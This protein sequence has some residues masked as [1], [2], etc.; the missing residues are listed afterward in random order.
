M[1]QYQPMSIPTRVPLIVNPENRNNT[2]EKDAR[3]INCYVEIDAGNN[4]NLYRRPGR[5]LWG[6]PPNSARLGFGVYWWN[7]AVYS[8]FEDRLYKNMAEV[9]S[10]LD[11]TRGVYTFTSI[12][13]A[14]PKLVFQN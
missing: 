12:M 1:P 7:G 4:V 11:I 6:S 10:G 2:T 13:G 9:G 8:I 5:D 14:T 3:L